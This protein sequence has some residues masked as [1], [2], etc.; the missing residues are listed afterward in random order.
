[1]GDSMSWLVCDAN[2]LDE[3]KSLL[4]AEDLKE[5]QRPT[6]YG[7]VDKSNRL[8]IFEGGG[9]WRFCDNDERQRL[10]TGREIHFCVWDT[11]TMF[12]HYAFWK[13]GAEIF[14]I[15]HLS[16]EGTYH[17]EVDGELP[18]SFEEHKRRLFE[19]QGR[20]EDEG[21]CVN[22]VIEVPM[23]LAKEA[24]GFDVEGSGPE[25]DYFNWYS[26]QSSPLGDTNE[27][28]SRPDL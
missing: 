5:G 4:G 13:D 21:G 26:E 8:F 15:T 22:Y 6:F 20:E 23:E 14:S 1:M 3:L 9:D 25:G 2:S 12:S 16:C 24:T 7:T 27:G 19:E 17:L 11:R 18:A 10:S 28:L